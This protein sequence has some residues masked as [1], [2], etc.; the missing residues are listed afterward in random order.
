[1]KKSS[2]SLLSRGLRFAFGISLGLAASAFAQSDRGLLFGVWAARGTPQERHA[3]ELPLT[4]SARSLAAGY[5]PLTDD[6]VRPC[7]PPGMPVMLATQSPIEFV[8]RGGRVVVRY[9]EWEGERTVYLAGGDRPPVQEPSPWGVSFGRWEGATLAIF[10]TYIDYPYF[11]DRG[12]PQSA[13]VGVLERYTPSPDGLRLDWEVTV[14][15]DAT[16]TEPVVLR[17]F[18]A[19]EPDRV[20]EPFRCTQLDS[21]L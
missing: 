9:E 21:S 8:D 14:T 2:P 11:D 1:V 7:I 10:T 13:G 4:E 5:D 17:G 19:R 3:D 15:D 18:M 6:P 12:T 20:I 16:F